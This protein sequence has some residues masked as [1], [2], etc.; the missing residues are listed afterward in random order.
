MKSSEAGV[1]PLEVLEE[2]DHGPCSAIRSKKV[3]QAAKRTSRRLPAR[4][5]RRGA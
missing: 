1:G 3:R 4:A 2:Q 5:P